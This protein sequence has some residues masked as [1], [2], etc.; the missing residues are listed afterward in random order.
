MTWGEF[1][2]KMADAGV[3]D[4]DQLWYIDTQFDFDLEIGKSDKLGVYVS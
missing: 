3:V 1:K 4:S 2:Q